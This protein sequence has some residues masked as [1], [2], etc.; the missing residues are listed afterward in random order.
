MRVKSTVRESSGHLRQ[1]RAI[2]SIWSGPGSEIEQD[3]VGLLGMEAFL[4]P[5]VSYLLGIDSR[6]YDFPEFQK[7]G[8]SKCQSGRV[9]DAERREA[10]SRNSN[11]VLGQGP[12]SG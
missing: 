5:P 6:L 4:M 8:S 3:L 7:V 2:V 1:L 10:Q 11:S 9:A 12:V